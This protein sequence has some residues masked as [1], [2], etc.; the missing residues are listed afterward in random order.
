MKW[1]EARKRTGLDKM[2]FLTPAISHSTGNCLSRRMTS[3]EGLEHLRSF[4]IMRG[5]EESEARGYTTHSL[6]RTLLDYCSASGAFTY[7]ERR[8]LGHH[9]SGLR[10]ELTYSSDEMSRLQAKVFRMIYTIKQGLFDPN[11]SGAERIRKET[12]DLVALDPEADDASSDSPSEDFHENLHEVLPEDP[13][14]A[15][16]QSADAE[17]QFPGIELGVRHLISGIIHFVADDEQTKLVCGRVYSHN[18]TNVHITKEMVRY[19]S[20]CKQCTDGS[21]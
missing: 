4:L 15:D 16:E 18:Y 2:D 6:K 14:A 11:A 10:S 1:V 3:A 20:V 8:C 12:T 19:E 17:E 7:E 9:M 13:E 5:L 21:K